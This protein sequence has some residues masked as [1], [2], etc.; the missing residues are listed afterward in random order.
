MGLK[1]S[2]K[3]RLEPPTD[4]HFINKAIPDDV[5]GEFIQLVMKVAT[6][7]PKRQD[8]L[9]HF[10]RH[11]CIARGA[12]YARSSSEGWAESDLLTYAQEAAENAPL[13][14]EA[15][16]NACESFG[17]DDPDLWAPDAEIINGILTKN[18]IGYVIKPPRLEL[19]ENIHQ[20]ASAP[21]TE[22]AIAITETEA[23]RATKIFISYRRSDSGAAAGRLYD[24]LET[25][26][27]QE[28][29]FMDVD[30][31]PFGKDFKEE[32]R[33]AIGESAIVLVVIG[34]NF[35]TEERRLF[36]DEDFVR[37]EIAYAFEQGKVVIPVKV[38]GAVMPYPGD[39]PDELRRLS[40]IN[41]PELRNE[42]WKPDCMGFWKQLKIIY[43][44]KVK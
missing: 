31:I 8:V 6:Q 40:T 17:E 21:K 22:P 13:F 43:D 15:F 14:I 2:G 11:F 32:I 25:E 44:E 28:N 27:G 24:F 30:K 10:K 36:D 12:M 33:K 26:M 37:F 9:E 39:L 7:G 34:R 42:R 41:S 16:Y 35:I 4:G 19:R 1:F 20:I 18:R 3:W 38:D 23:N 29:L 5:V